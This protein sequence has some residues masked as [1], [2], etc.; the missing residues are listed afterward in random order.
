MKIF[1]A[2]VEDLRSLYTDHLEKALDMEKKITSSL[3]K[4]I[5]HSTDSELAAAFRT[6]LEETRGHVATVEDILRKHLGDA[7][8]K[9]CRGMSGLVTEASETM[10]DVTDPTIRDMALIGAAQQVE[11]HEIAVYG[12]LRRWAELL[13][14]DEDAKALEGIEA[15]EENADAV[16]TDIAARV[17]REGA[18]QEE[19]EQKH[20]S[21]VEE[22]RPAA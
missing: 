10:S 22:K 5:E 7:P 21:R 6:H 20:M 4:L 9:S 14:F 8:S 13:E 2:H 11:H 19:E 17:N 12:T 3:P 16:L 1:S 18:S 15:E